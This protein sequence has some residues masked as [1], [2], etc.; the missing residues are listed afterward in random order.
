MTDHSELVE[1]VA[2]LR[3]LL[4]PDQGDIASIGIKIMY[5]TTC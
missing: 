3:D 5:G 1:A 4:P 2:A